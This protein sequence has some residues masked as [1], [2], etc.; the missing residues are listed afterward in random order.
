MICSNCGGN[1]EWQGRL[2]NLTHTKCLKCGAINSQ[3]VENYT[4][5]EEERETIWMKDCDCKNATATTNEMR[6]VETVKE[7]G[8]IIGTCGFI[9]EPSCNNC[10]RAWKIKP[11]GD[12]DAMSS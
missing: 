1:V 6:C 2:T 3:V 4:I 10:G 9:P 7:N 5:D 8:A 11:Q 12:T